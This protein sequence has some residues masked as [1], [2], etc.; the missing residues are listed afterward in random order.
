MIDI[1]CTYLP[2]CG[3]TQ[4]VNLNIAIDD[5]SNVNLYNQSNCVYD[6]SQLQYAYSVDNLC[7]SCYMTFDEAVA[8]TTTLNSDFYLRIKVKGPVGSLMNGNEK[9]LDYST[10]LA[11][12][13]E[14][15]Y[16]SVANASSNQYNPYANM[17]AAIALQQQLNENVA[18][19]S[20]IPIYYFKLSPNV[21]SKDITFKEY[22]LMDVESVKQIKLIVGEGTLPSARPEF[23][24]W[25]L[26]WQADWECEITKGQFATAFGPTAQP[27]EGD[28]IYIPMM[29]RMWMV[30]GAW[31]EK[32]ESLMW[33]GTTFTVTLVK[34][35]EKGSVNL[36][37]TEQLVN[38]FVKNK[39]E[40]LFGEDD[41]NTFDSGEQTTDAPIYAANSLYSVFESDATRKYV[42]CDTINIRNNEKL[43]YKGTLISDSQYSFITPN[44]TST[45]V[46]QSQYCG[47][48]FTISFIFKP[49]LLANDTYK[50]SLISIG[51]FKIIINQMHNK[52]ELY[53]NKNVDCKLTL[54]TDDTYF[55]ILR[56]NKQMNLID[57]NAYLYTF[58]TNVPR[59]KLQNVHYY[60]DIDN[61]IAT[62]NSKFDIEYNIEQKS[63][64]ELHGFYGTI[65]NIKLFDVYNDNISEILQMYPTH[66]H[67]IINDTARKIL[68]GNG[69][70]LK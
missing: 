31:E 9:I 59:Y 67:L 26:D 32:N 44:I 49:H 45:V 33:V 48:T 2:G 51:K 21:G 43:W 42:T 66:Q 39:Y 47:D 13:F 7:W 56:V 29:K 17:D 4:I 46:Y 38:S 16:S 34:Y 35:Q 22:T 28:L 40:D 61:P 68:D 25:G 63:N 1:N 41:M 11:S 8:N 15:S 55:V 18:A 53:V 70:L 12:C 30:N 3:P 14:F 36:G 65:T 62:Y 37:D 64:V 23:A 5:M 54:N 10:Q 60:F 20:G 57:F 27:M 52:C 58:N 69:V 19:I 6:K 50:N 24:E